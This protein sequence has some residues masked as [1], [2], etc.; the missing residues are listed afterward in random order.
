MNDWHLAELVTYRGTGCGITPDAKRNVTRKAAHLETIMLHFWVLLW[1]LL[2][3][4]WRRP[5]AISDPF[6][7]LLEHRFARP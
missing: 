3:P 2:Q 4:G 5:I 7:G 1:V 6:V